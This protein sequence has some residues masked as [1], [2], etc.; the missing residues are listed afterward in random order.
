VARRGDCRGTDRHDCLGTREL[1]TT[2]VADPTGNPV[3]RVTPL[4]RAKGTEVGVRTV[5]LRHLQSALLFWTLHLDS[6]LLYDGD[7]GATEPGPASKRYGIEF[8]N[9]YALRPWLVFDG[10]VA[11]SQAR[12]TEFNEAG[13]YVPEAVDVVVSGGASV[14]NFHRMFGSL[15]LRYFGPRPLVEDNSVRSQATTLLNLEAGYRL[16]SNV[17][18][19]LEVF[20]LANATVSDIDYYFPSRLPGEPAAGVEDFH[21]HPSAPRTA[22]IGLA[23]GF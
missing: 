19:S 20:N 22:R 12:F 9:Y 15:R 6:K 10:D 18:V 23:V 21:T 2:I 5:A 3:D 7:V 13:Q 14:D 4:V 17:R 1:G 11:W 16:H 8:A